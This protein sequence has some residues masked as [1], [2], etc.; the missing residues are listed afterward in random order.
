MYRRD[1]YDT[2]HARL[3]GRQAAGEGFLRALVRHGRTSPISCV[4]RSRAEFDDFCTLVRPWFIGQR[5]VRWVDATSLASLATCGTLHRPDGMLADEAFRRRYATGGSR[6]FGITGVTH[7]IASRA[8]LRAVSDLL[9]APLEPWDALVC[10]SKA[11][12]RAVD[13][14]L[15]TW[16]DYLAVRTGGRPTAPLR[17]PV[18]PLGIHC[19]SFPQGAAREA[20]RARIRDRISAEDSDI[21]ALFV[22]RLIFYAKAHPAPMYLALERAARATGRTIH[23]VQAG[24]F[25]NDQE[26]ED[27]RTSASALAPSV[28][29]HFL[30][31]RKIDVRTE[32]WAGA[33]LFLSLSDNIQETFGLTPI[34][35]MANGLPVIVTDWDGYRESVRHEIDGMCVPTMTP[36]AGAASEWAASYLADDLGY[37][38]YIAYCSMSTAVD[39]D[40]CTEAVRRLIDNEDLRR[41]LG[42]SGRQRAREVYDWSVVI[43]AY[44]ELWEELADVREHAASA[45]PPLVDG[46]PPAPLLDDPFRQFAHYPT[47]IVDDHTRV[48]LGQMAS[49]AGLGKLAQLFSFRFGV[50]ERAGDDF[51]QQVLAFVQT[52]GTVEVADIAAAHPSVP[53]GVVTRTLVHLAKFD[54]LKLTVVHTAK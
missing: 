4:A 31:G 48:G 37:S 13:Q 39:V 25:E 32:V 26:A 1:G 49:S 40:A 3:L 16:G 11:V 19:D 52:R 5:Q 20:A 28:Q 44:E 10:T 23:L 50:G 36:A 47:A 21:V 42:E 41:R 2:G 15:T 17:L 7:T 35:A 8:A 30:D 6:A 14:V 9:I 53:Y 33:D 34:E 24:W 45:S 12:K 51:V 18:I 29:C 43:R 38:N 54:V 46:S 22:G 27:F